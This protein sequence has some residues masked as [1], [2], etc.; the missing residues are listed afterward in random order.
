[1]EGLLA[2][3]H[4]P[5][6]HPEGEHVRLRRGE[7]P[8]EHLHRH[9]L[10]SASRALAGVVGEAEIGHLGGKVVVHQDVRGLDVV[11]DHR[12][13]A[14]VEEGHAL[15]DVQDGFEQDE[16]V[17]GRLGVQQVLHGAPR[18]ELR[19]EHQLARLGV[20]RGP[21]QHHDVGVPQ[22]GHLPDLLVEKLLVARLAELSG[23]ALAHEARSTRSTKLARVVHRALQAGESRGLR[24]E[25]A[26]AALGDERLHS[27]VAAPELGFAHLAEGARAEDAFVVAL[28]VAVAVAEVQLGVLHFPVF[29]LGLGARHPPLVEDHH[30]H[31]DEGQAPDGPHEPPH[32]AGRE[33]ALGPRVFLLAGLQA[34]G[35]A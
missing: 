21:H 8:L 4:L 24:V 32:D 31:E 30:G 33:P 20:H 10:R 9:V 19:D 2:G 25:A 1:M 29:S 34:S 6:R 23:E 5:D 13:L 3:H 15:G 27:D 28:A 11:V 7:P 18:H 22:L 17:E 35:R 14:R 16:H 26:A 12:G